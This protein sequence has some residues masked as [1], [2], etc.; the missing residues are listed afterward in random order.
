MEH[1]F[2]VTLYNALYDFSTVV[3]YNHI[4]LCYALLCH[5]MLHHIILFYVMLYYVMTEC[6]VTDLRFFHIYICLG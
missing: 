6:F 3:I 5:V 4:M 1:L 2:F